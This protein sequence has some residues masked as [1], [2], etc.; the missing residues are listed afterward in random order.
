MRKLLDTSNTIE[1]DYIDAA[2]FDSSSPTP[3]W[4]LLRGCNDQY[5]FTKRVYTSG[6]V[7][8]EIKYPAGASIGDAAFKT[9]YEYSGSDLI[10]I[11]QIPYIIASGDLI[12]PTS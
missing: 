1:A 8:T 10:G 3:D 12:S 6:F 5:M 2:G 4:Q 7:S 9:T 11:C